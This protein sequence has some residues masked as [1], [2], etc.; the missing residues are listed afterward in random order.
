MKT[1]TPQDDRILEIVEPVAED[2]GYKVVRIRV[3][4][5]KRTVL[6]I[7]AERPDGTMSVADCAKL[8]RALSAV[9]DVEDPIRG[10]Y[11][12]EVSSA[13]V[14][15]PLT[16]LEDF[17]RYEGFEAKLELDR[18]AEGRKRFKGTLAG[19]DDG[20]VCLDMDGE[21][22]LILIPFDWLSDAKLVITDELMK[23]SAK[24]AKAARNGKTD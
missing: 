23:A 15:R 8:S 17:D 3:M 2:L 1:K 10:E 9:M 13:G 20:N 4:G 11:A 5:S 24:A 19:T 16:R 14:D 22:D 6:Q 12:L 18:M 7:M 21:D